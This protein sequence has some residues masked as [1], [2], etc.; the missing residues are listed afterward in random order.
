[1]QC[2][3]SHKFCSTC[4]FVW[5]NTGLYENRVRCPVCRIPG[6][7]SPNDEIDERVAAKKVKCHLESCTWTGLAKQINSHHHNNY[8]NDF[9]SEAESKTSGNTT[10]SSSFPRLAQ[11]PPRVPGS[12]TTRFVGTGLTTFGSNNESPSHHITTP[13]RVP[14]LGTRVSSRASTSSLSS[15][16]QETIIDL[17]PQPS[18]SGGATS[19][20]ISASGSTRRIPPI[21]ASAAA[22][23]RITFSHTRA[24]NN[25][26]G[27][28][29]TSDS[30]PTRSS[31]SNLANS[32]SSD[33]VPN[34]I[35]GGL[36]PH[37][38]AAP[39]TSSNVINARRLPR[40]VNAPPQ[41]S[42]PDQHI[43]PTSNQGQ[44]AGVMA[45]SSS[46]PFSPPIRNPATSLSEIRDH[47]QDSRSRLNNLMSSFSGELDRNRQEMMEFQQERERQRRD[48]LEEVREL[49]QRL[50]QVAFELRRLLEQRRQLP[51]FSD[52]DSDSDI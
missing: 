48:Q 29:Q 11:V 43:Q 24:N 30:V 13:R 22:N 42:Q 47:L 17:N 51:N 38:P 35:N 15:T 8:G 14:L 23:N 45:T 16:S 10:T 18:A 34:S 26:G 5:R 37:P 28:A 4:I 36:T 52:S 2:A 32:N 44:G 7:Y 50:G 27:A 6:G 40:L 31:V 25:V 49:G 20:I 3:N 41:R 39:R 33:N 46:S 9:Q 21:R 1:M 12:S 19:S